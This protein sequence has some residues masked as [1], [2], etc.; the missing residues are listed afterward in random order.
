M[1]ISTVLPDLQKYGE[2]EIRL[3]SGLHE[4]RL[5]AA[6]IK[7]KIDWKNTLVASCSEAQKQQG[8]QAKA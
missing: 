5:R 3:H 6:T 4:V 7:E 2:S 8:F 1:Q